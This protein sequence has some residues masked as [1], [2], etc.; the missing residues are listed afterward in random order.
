[1]NQVIGICAKIGLFLVVTFGC[2]IFGAVIV[3]WIAGAIYLAVY[4]GE[5][6]DPMQASEACARGMAV[7]YLSIFAGGLLGAI[8]V[9]LC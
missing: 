9:L 2:M 6:I 5:H 7:G 3:Y 8:L 1:M 4:S